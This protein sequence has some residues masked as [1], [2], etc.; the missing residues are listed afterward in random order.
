MVEAVSQTQR[1]GDGPM[2]ANSSSVPSVPSARR[3]WRDRDFLLFWGG[4]TVSLIGTQV[5]TLALPLAAILALNAD[6]RQLGF[7]RTAEFLP[8]IF[9][10]LL[11]GPWVDSHRRLPIMVLANVA[12]GTLIA[13]VPLLYAL[14]VLRMPLLYA[15]ALLIGV[16]TVLFDL[17][18]LSYLPR[19]VRREQIV[20][21]NSKIVASQSFAPVVGPGMGGF[22]VGLLSAPVTLLVDAASYAIS[23]VTMLLIRRPEPQLERQ[24]RKEKL[25]PAIS[26]GLRIVF[27]NPYLRA[28]AGEGFTFNFFYQFIE[29]LFVLYAVRQ[30]GFSA[31][32]IGLIIGTGSVGAVVGSAFASRLAARLRFG[33][34]LVRSMWVACLAPMLI[35]LAAGGKR[36]EATV[37]ILA[38]FLIGVGE[39]VANVLAV[40][41]R[42]TVTPDRL[43][44][45]MNASMRLALY[46]AAPLGALAAG[47]LGEAIGLR[48]AFVVAAVG[49]VVAMLFIVFSPIPALEVPPPDAEEPAGE[50]PGM[51]PASR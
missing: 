3:L 7:L 47:F 22:L 19:L 13:L 16:G 28:I 26:Q 32:S 29:V 12:R 42:Q 23:V 31:Q 30:L 35:P 44:G 6:S 2:T 34:A 4:E 38:F 21:G 24:E 10:T 11:V 25:L 14:G 43:L 8:F 1:E 51:Q 5:T 37:L 49:F 33:P 50:A 20:E 45:R 46:G 27:G 17:S 15:I 40:S 39:G 18:Y 41:L 48:P 9:L 36:F